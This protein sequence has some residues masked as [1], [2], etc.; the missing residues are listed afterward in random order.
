MSDPLVV[1]ITPLV[2]ALAP[3]ALFGGLYLK[4]SNRADRRA[5]EVAELRGENA[6]LRRFIGCNCDL[7]RPRAPDTE[8]NASPSSKWDANG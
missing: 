1:F 5:V 3:V 4:A 7:K 6:A 8:K 2:A